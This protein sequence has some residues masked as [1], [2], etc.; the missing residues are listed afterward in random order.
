MMFGLVGLGMEAFDS[1]QTP[2]WQRWLARIVV[3]GLLLVSLV[4]GFVGMAYLSMH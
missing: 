3:A 1:K 2:F 4:A